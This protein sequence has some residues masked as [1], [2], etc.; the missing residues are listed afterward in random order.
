MLHRNT[1][2]QDIKKTQTLNLNIYQRQHLCFRRRPNR[3]MEPWSC[4]LPTHRENI[5]AVFHSYRSVQCFTIWVCLMKLSA[6]MTIFGCTPEV[7]NYSFAVRFAQGV[8]PEWKKFQ[9][10]WCVW[11]FVCVVFQ[12]LL[13]QTSSDRGLW[14]RKVVF[15]AAFCGRPV[16]NTHT[17]LKS[18][19][20][21]ILLRVIDH[22]SPPLPGWHVHWELHLHYRS[23]LQDQDHRHGR[24][25]SETTDCKSLFIRWKISS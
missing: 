12:W 16:K 8:I 25:D 6:I 2:K 23:W 3:K 22:I 18:L 19:Y 20:S 9:M 10:S 13:V 14:S 15:A 7:C 1:L 11:T 4:S 17:H 24:E 21:Q 5:P